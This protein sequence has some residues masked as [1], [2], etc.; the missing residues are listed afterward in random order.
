MKELNRHPLYREASEMYFL[1]KPYRY[2]RERELNWKAMLSSTDYERAESLCDF[3]R[4]VLGLDS[5]P[6]DFMDGDTFADRSI[7]AD[8]ELERE[9]EPYDDFRRQC[10]LAFYRHIFHNTVS[11]RFEL[12]GFITDHHSLELF[13]LWMNGK[14][15]LK[16]FRDSVVEVS[17]ILRTVRPMKSTIGFRRDMR[18]MYGIFREITRKRAE[19]Q[20]RNADVPARRK[21]EIMHDG[22]TFRLVKVNPTTEEVEALDRRFQGC[23][24]CWMC[25]LY[26]EESHVAS[27]RE[28]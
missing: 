23:V 16:L 14:C 5:S 9:L 28:G 19:R 25:G 6:S 3:A 10:M 24:I 2:F 22:M 8:R 4:S 15:T 7:D 12:G 20:L 11:P 1:L 18:R 27:Y 13:L 17:L 26:L 21:R